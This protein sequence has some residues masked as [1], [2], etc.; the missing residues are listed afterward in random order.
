MSTR[1]TVTF[2]E[3]GVNLVKLYNHWDGY[4][5]GLGNDI[6]EWLN[7]MRIG[8]G[9][10]AGDNTYFA[11]G[12]G[13]LV[14]QFIRDFKAEPGGLYVIPIDADCEEYNYYINIDYDDRGTVPCKD[15]CKIKVTQGLYDFEAKEDY[16]NTIFDG[17][18]EEFHQWIIDNGDQ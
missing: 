17:N 8:N 12:V 18:L 13:C 16:E 4:P 3:N 10:G 1:A 11:N 9:I 5:T 15:I 14:A 7:D 2:S 6:A